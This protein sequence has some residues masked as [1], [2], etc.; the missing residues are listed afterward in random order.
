[1][2]TIHNLQQL[3]TDDGDLVH[4]LTVDCLFSDNVYKL[5]HLVYLEVPVE[6]QK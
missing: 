5:P 4:C 2:L 1:M 6:V 3:T